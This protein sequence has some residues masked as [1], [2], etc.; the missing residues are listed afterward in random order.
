MRGYAYDL[1]G[2]RTQAGFGA[3]STTNPV[4][5]STIAYTYDAANRLTQIAD[6]A[7]G[8]LACSPHTVVR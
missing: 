3:S 8:T 1:L 6:S 7:N 5:E 4:Y 2:R